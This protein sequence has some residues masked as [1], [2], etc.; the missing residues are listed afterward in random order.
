M[1]FAAKYSDYYKR[2]FDD[3]AFDYRSD[4]TTL[5]DI[6]LLPVICKK[7]LIRFNSAIHTV[8]NFEFSKL[9]FAETSG[10]TGEAL[11]FFKDEYWDSANRA[12]IQR[13]MSWYGVE[14]W[15]RNGYFWGFNFSRMA[16]VR[17]AVQDWLL[18][19]FR[20]FTYEDKDILRFIEKSRQAIYIHGY[21]S[22]IY[23]VAK[24]ANELGIKLCDIS[25][26]KGT[27][28][29]I[30]P[31][32]H[33]ETRKAFG[34]K[35]IS[36]YGAAE[37][38]IIAFECPHGSMH[39]NEEMC[40]VEVAQGQIIVTNLV[41]RS[42]PVIRYRLGDYIRLSDRKCE[43]GRQHRIIEEVTGRVGKSVVG[44]TGK[45]FPSLTFYY[46][47]KNLALDKNIQ[48]NYKAIQESP[49]E[50]RLL[51]DRNL[52]PDEVRYLRDEFEKY[53]GSEL[54][55]RL[56]E[57]VKLHDRKSKLMDFESLL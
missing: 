54:V 10:S 30:Y 34:L 4:L 16:K 42:F 56:E 46:I 6:K 26:I 3:H 53:F 44:A 25:L 51:L 29:K 8:D 50:L 28:E 55:V 5:D 24:R 32:Y 39:I 36:E 37:T 12:S 15:Q 35:I 11:T 48:I 41:G 47:F 23:E 13:G 52:S 43:C 9:F 49:G 7:D 27:S 2:V 31:H 57:N 33:D 17:I 14:P 45:K 40:I 22:M 19:R 1:K 21:S 18:N 20:I 38:G